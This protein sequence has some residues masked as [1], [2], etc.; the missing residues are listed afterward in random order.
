MCA[1]RRVGREGV[2]VAEQPEVNWSHSVRASVRARPAY[3]LQTRL[4]RQRRQK[5][6]ERTGGKGGGG[7]RRG[8]E[9]L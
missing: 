6:R 5:D 2:E 4:R 1:G 8:V 7:R 9:Y 3:D